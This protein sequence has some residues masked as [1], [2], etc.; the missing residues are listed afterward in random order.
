MVRSMKRRDGGGDV[1]LA[2]RKEGGWHD[3]TASD[4]N[5][6]IREISGGE[7]T[8]KDFRT[9]HATVLAAVGLAVSD[10]AVGTDTA[11]K[12][13]VVRAVTEVA[14]YLGNTPAAARGS[15][16]DPRVIEEFSRGRTVARALSE[17]ATRSEFGEPATEDSVEN[18]VLRLLGPRRLA[19]S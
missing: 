4:I 19:D 13:A 8:A 3:V 17:L 15:Y 7:F 18:A 1:L 10:H 14:A 2:Y 12:R 9:W 6:Y 5:D 11:R 16:I